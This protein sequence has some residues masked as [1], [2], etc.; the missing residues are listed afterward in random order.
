MKKNFYYFETAEKSFLGIFR[1]CIRLR[2]QYRGKKNKHKIEKFSY[3][4]FW[5]NY[6][7]VHPVLRFLPTDRYFEMAEL[8]LNFDCA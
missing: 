5:Y 8:K 2:I 7:I 3:Y 1:Y 6:G 4:F